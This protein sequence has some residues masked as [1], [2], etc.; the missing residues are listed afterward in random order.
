MLT[1]MQVEFMMLLCKGS[2]EVRLIDNSCYH[3][4]NIPYT[5]LP[6]VSM[7]FHTCV[8]ASHGFFILPNKKNEFIMMEVLNHLGH[9]LHF[10]IYFERS[11]FQ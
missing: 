11:D 4:F 9:R 8:H 2:D 6:M 10:N 5:V 7:V 1:Q 3:Q